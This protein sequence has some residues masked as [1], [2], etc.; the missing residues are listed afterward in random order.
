[1][2]AE[3][4]TRIKPRPTFGYEAPEEALNLMKLASRHVSGVVA[5]TRAGYLLLSPAEVAARAAFEASVRAAWMLMPGD[6]FGQEARWLAHL[7]GEITYL[8][9]QIEEGTKEMQIDMSPTVE[10]R[11]SLASFHNK[12]VKLLV[13]RGHP[14]KKGLPPIPAMLKEIGETKTYALYC[15]LCQTAH[16]GHYSTW[17]FR[18]NG[19]GAKKARGDFVTEE[20]WSI[21][22][23]MARF[24]FKGP[25]MIMCDRFGL[26]TSGLK[27]LI[28]S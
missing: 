18:G 7:L 19:V 9:N 11:N 2:V 20:K 1:M 10:R 8:D 3:F 22:L 27:R 6:F 4:E 17:I 25:G 5:I 26:D 24:V 13:E 16:G 15:L 28:G 12:I 21:P 23:A 14:P